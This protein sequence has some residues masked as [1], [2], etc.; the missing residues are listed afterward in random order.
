MEEGKGKE[1]KEW[2]EFDVYITGGSQA[3]KNDEFIFSLKD[4]KI[5]K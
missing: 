5:E 4:G 3:S 2:N 1:R